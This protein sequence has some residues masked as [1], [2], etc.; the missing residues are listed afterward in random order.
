MVKSVLELKGKI[1]NEILESILSRGISKLTPPQESA[2]KNGLLKG[3]NL[4][5]SSPTASG[6]TLIAEI[7]CVTHI[8][9]GKKS[10]YIAPMKALVSEKYN[11]FCESYPYIKT[12]VSMGDLDSNDPWLSEYDMLFVS[13]EKFDSLVRHGIDWLHKIG[14]VV[15]DEVHM[16]GD[17]SRGPTLELVITKIKDVINPQIIAL[18]A[19][20]G[21]SD[22]IAKWLDATSITS[23]YRPVKLVKGVVKD[24]K[25]YIIKPTG[26]EIIILEGKSPIPEI[27]LL[28]D[29]VKKGK[30]LLIFFS[31]KRNA[32]ASASRLAEQMKYLNNYTNKESLK[33]V[34]TLIL[35]VLNSPTKQCEKLS[36]NI[37][38]GVAFHHSGLVNIQRNII[39]DAFKAGTIKAICST[40]TLGFGVNMPAHTVLIR[41]IFRYSAYGMD[42]IGVNEIMQLFGRAGRPK[43]D[44]EG[45][46]FIQCGNNY[47]V[48]EIADRYI[49]SDPEPIDSALGVAPVLRTH[50]LSF[51]AT[52]FIKDKKRMYEFMGKTLYSFQYGVES[53]LYNIISGVIDELNKW[54]FIQGTENDLSATR[55]GKRIS[56]LYIDPLSAKWIVENIGSS[57]DDISNLYMISN[58]IEMRSYIRPSKEKAGEI[59]EVFLKYIDS[60]KLIPTNNNTTYGFRDELGAFTTA[61]ALN[62]WMEEKTENL[63]LMDYHTTPG[64]LYSKISNADWMIYSAIELSKILHAPYRQLISTRVRLRYGIKEELLDLVRLEQIGR[65]RARK[66]YSNGIRGVSDIRS[67]KDLVIK[68]L[69][70]ETSKR[71]FVQLDMD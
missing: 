67:S 7:A 27:R 47:S 4:V 66:L 64:A 54:G 44:T 63:I 18:S 14:C 12:A 60:G 33:K 20:I 52:G 38:K 53:H 49:N 70:K 13:T 40:T 69:G 9:S 17:T 32:E 11:E 46:A 10:I 36:A 21:N 6:K 51:I 48:G 31:S 34:S 42:K 5:V 16:I 28:E 37:E 45:R 62:D 25:A 8:L 39:E 1:P 3:K 57:K 35:K 41:D 56:E 2:I 26:K 71:I 61:M 43:Y 22:E 68:I 50:I 15:F 19:T 59:E 30:Q 65:V 58:T 24:S 29:T 55:L 23:D